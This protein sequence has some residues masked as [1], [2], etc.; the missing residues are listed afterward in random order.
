MEIKLATTIFESLAVKK[1]A[2]L[3]RV[4]G[5]RALKSFH[6]RLFSDRFFTGES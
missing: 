6:P 1:R 5:K 3:F 4:L 2:K